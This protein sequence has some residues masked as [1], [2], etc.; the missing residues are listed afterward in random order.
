MDIKWRQSPNHSSR[1]GHTPDIISCHITQGSYA[2]A[3][4][5]LCNPESQASSHF[6]VS[7][8]GEITQLVDIRH[9]AWVNGTSTKKEKAYFNG[10]STLEAVRNRGVNANRYTIGIEHEGFYDKTL[11]ALTPEQEAATAALMEYIRAAVL[12]IY[13]KLIPADR[14]HIV[15][16]CNIAPKWKPNCPGPKFPYDSILKKLNEDPARISDIEAI[17]AAGVINSPQYWIDN[18]KPGKM[19]DGAYVQALIANMAKKIKGE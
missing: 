14:D 2:G 18:A 9:S 3:I 6:V 5:W 19:C 12:K 7:Q 15:G 13:G 11:G 4:S 1:E 8:K 10:H 17:K 16:H